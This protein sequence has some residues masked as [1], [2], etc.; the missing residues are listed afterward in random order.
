MLAGLER[1]FQW[2]LK[3]PHLLAWREGKWLR[4][5]QLPTGEGQQVCALLL[6]RTEG[7]SGNGLREGGVLLPFLCEHQ[8][9]GTITHGD[10]PSV[11]LCHKAP[12]LQHVSKNIVTRKI[13]NPL[14]SSLYCSALAQ[15]WESLQIASVLDDIR[16]P[17]QAWGVSPEPESC[18]RSLEMLPQKQCSNRLGQPGLLEEAGNSLAP[19][20]GRQ[21]LHKPEQKEATS[22]G[23]LC[24]LVRNRVACPT[25]PMPLL[26]HQTQEHEEMVPAAITQLGQEI[27]EILAP[28]ASEA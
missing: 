14:F 7:C 17:R 19:G 1:R 13:R 5:R 15:S 16:L 20:L 18:P 23:Q 26:H 10:I 9:F 27:Q 8:P 24:L 2:P 3:K 22:L 25:P 21:Q 28:L 12:K 11:F 6:R 4:A